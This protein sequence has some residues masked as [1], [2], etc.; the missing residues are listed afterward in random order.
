M[1][2][3]LLM[4]WT[5]L[6]IVASV[7]LMLRSRQVTFQNQARDR[8]TSDELQRLRKI[9]AKRDEALR[10]VEQNTA[11]L[12]RYQ[13]ITARF[14]DLLTIPELVNIIINDGVGVLGGVAGAVV[15]RRAGSNTCEIIGSTGHP[16][17]LID[18]WQTFSIDAPLITAAVIRIGQ[19]MWIHNRADAT[20]R[21]AESFENNEINQAWA[22][23]PLTVSGSIFGALSISF[24]EPQRFG[25]DDRTFIMTLVQ[26]CSNAIER[27]QLYTKTI[28]QREEY[29]VTLASIGDAVIATDGDGLVTFMNPIAQQMTGWGENE[30]RGLALPQVFTLLDEALQPLENPFDR[31]IRQGEPILSSQP[32]LL[33]VRDDRPDQIQGATRK[34]FVESSGA[35]IRDDKGTLR[36][37]VLVFR[38]V[39]KRRQQ[40]A[41]LEQ[42]L[43]RT[44]DLYETCHQIGLGYNAEQVLNA[45]FHSRYLN[46]AAQAVYLRFDSDWTTRTPTCFDTLAR[47]VP[48]H[49]LPGLADDLML[50]NS[51]LLRLYT[52]EDPVFIDTVA[53]D[54][55]LDLTLRTLLTD[56]GIQSLILYP[57][58]A[59]N[60]A[61]GAMIVYFRTATTWNADDLRHIET[62]IDQVSIALD[63][64][65]LLSEERDARAEAEQANA[66][67][68]RF[69]AMISHELRTP[70]ASIKGFTTTLLA[71]DVKWTSEQQHEFIEIINEEANKLT[72]MIEQLLDLSRL[73]A[74]TLRIE[75]APQHLA[76]LLRGAQ[77]A[78]EALATN[79]QL[80]ID[81]AVDLP[82]VWA[83]KLR[84]EQVLSNLVS[85]ATKFSADGTTIHISF[86]TLPD[87]V[88]ISVHDEGPGIPEAFR[89]QVF[90][91]FWQLP[92]TIRKQKNKGAGLG[93][94][95]CK[96]L[97]EAHGSHI[98]IDATDEPGTTVSFTLPLVTQPRPSGFMAEPSRR[99]H[100]GSERY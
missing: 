23:I 25:I 62:F 29:R 26:K 35:P 83:D 5:V 15:V 51:P 56:N 79:R 65:H 57:L 24:N 94:A 31:V 1:P 12:T 80:V 3:N 91:A 27:T 71:P 28:D 48:D 78:L 59:H 77:R 84:V 34:L 76:G 86:A 40:E 10:L 100:V 2:I 70:L 85:N 63:N 97:V 21:F 58:T 82:N 95:I 90:A 8:H 98:W 53:T 54:N 55:R 74:G 81:S 19:P 47:L 89:E 43:L 75:P 22:S 36:G 61:F 17:A 73:Q 30:A 33:Q 64:D 37:V 72:D 18:R 92:E 67:R 50:A 20:E 16:K 9:V 6:L 14:S 11:R 44:Q 45:Q 93:L 87:V 69:L 39:S 66:A 13:L 32:A 4:L 88:Q 52:T 38:D 46:N 96:G 60:H 99:V 7:I 49:P 41:E 42:T 68:L